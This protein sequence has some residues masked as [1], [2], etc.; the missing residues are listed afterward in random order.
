MFV[1]IFKALIYLPLT[2]EWYDTPTIVNI[3]TNWSASKL[4]QHSGIV[5]L[6]SLS[7]QGQTSTRTTTLIES[8]EA[9]SRNHRPVLEGHLFLHY[10]VSHL[11]C[12]IGFSHQLQQLHAD[13]H[14][15]TSEFQIQDT[16]CAE[17]NTVNIYELEQNKGL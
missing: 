5:K 2:F 9:F 6:H 12:L 3:K 7:P 1:I 4:C 11:S 10:P 14:L 8:T 15:L 16:K 17:Q 13:P